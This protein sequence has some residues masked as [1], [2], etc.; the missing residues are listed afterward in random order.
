VT[1]ARLGRGGDVSQLHPNSEGSR[2][3]TEQDAVDF[4][5][6]RIRRIAAGALLAVSAYVSNVEIV[7]Q[8]WGYLLP[9]PLSGWALILF[10]AGLMFLVRDL[11]PRSAPM[12]LETYLASAAA[13]FM[14]AP[15]LG[16]LI[17]SSVTPLPLLALGLLAIEVFPSQPGFSASVRRASAALIAAVGVTIW[18]VW[19]SG[20]ADTGVGVV[21]NSMLVSATLWAHA[22]I[23]LWFGACNAQLAR[24][25]RSQ[26]EVGVTE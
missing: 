10:P 11:P 19:G 2:F 13:A 16:A 9:L 26:R 14:L 12:V 20:Y 6:P 4:V 7:L 17:F 15:A 22:A 18:T 24:T 21:E 3:R 23:W 8:T 5:Q 1:L 25:Y